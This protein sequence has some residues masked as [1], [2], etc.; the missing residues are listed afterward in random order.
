MA[1]GADTPDQRRRLAR[2]Q[3]QVEQARQQRVADLRPLAQERIR[4]TMATLVD[5]KT[6]FPGSSDEFEAQLGRTL[7]ET[8]GQVDALA[9]AA[10]LPEAAATARRRVELQ[11]TGFDRSQEAI[12]GETLAR[13]ATLEARQS[14]LPDGLGFA[15]R[16][17]RVLAQNARV[18]FKQKKGI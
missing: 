3:R 18:L 1:I 12:A 5:M 15:P 4:E 2:Q 11:P 7:K 13:T 8:L 6:Q 14:Q 9:R 16:L 17:S 10:G